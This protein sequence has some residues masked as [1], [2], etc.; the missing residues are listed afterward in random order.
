MLTTWDLF[1]Q[2]AVSAARQEAVHAHAHRGMDFLRQVYAP[3]VSGLDASDLQ[4]VVELAYRHAAHAGATS[5]R[6]QVQYLVPV[7]SWG[8]YFDSDPQYHQVLAGAGWPSHYPASQQQMAAVLNAI[9]AGIDEFETHVADDY[10]DVARILWAFEDVGN[11]DWTQSDT[12]VLRRAVGHVWP[13]RSRWLG[14]RGVD[15]CCQAMISQMQH[16]DLSR[17]EIALLT[18]MSFQLGHG[19]CR[20]PLYPWIRSSL[21]QP[22]SET[23]RHALT[24]GLKD[25][26]RRRIA[27][28]STEGF[29]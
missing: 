6:L 1:S 17:A 19:L 20:D 26:Y 12:V 13:V 22:P 23:R 29:V 2:E 14:A 16:Y 27:A 28:V 10:R 24:Q 25:S 3:V 21:E 4:E 11:H 5:T 8:S 18:C 7:A 15:Y 9:A